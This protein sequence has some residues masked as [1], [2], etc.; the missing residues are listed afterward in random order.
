MPNNHYLLN[1]ITQRY[2]LP[3]SGDKEYLY[4]HLHAAGLDDRFLAAILHSFEDH[5]FNTEEFAPFDIE[6]IVDYIQHTHVLYLQKTLPELEQSI[7]LLSNHYEEGHPLLRQLH[8]FFH[9]YYQ[10]LTTHV[11][12]EEEKFLPYVALL[13]Q[14]HRNPQHFS[15]YI[16]TCNNYSVR[17]FLDGHHDTED[18]L[19]GIRSIIRQYTPPPTNQSLYRILLLQLQ[20]F[21]QDLHVHA[22]ME[23]EVLIPKALELEKSLTLK[24]TEAGQRN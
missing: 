10:D 15:S 21:E 19:A 18:E 3:L 7:L 20:T 23:E 2:T 1:Q 13:G 12:E 5:P 24:I 11:R 6:M 8:G 17:Q 16:T 9:S 22:Q 14:A 4:S